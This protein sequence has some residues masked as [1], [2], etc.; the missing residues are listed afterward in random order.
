MSS[1]AVTLWVAGEEQAQ[2]AAALV[3]DQGHTVTV[4]GSDE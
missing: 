1:G 3:R 2:R 4:L